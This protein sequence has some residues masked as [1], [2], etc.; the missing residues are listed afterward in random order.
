M[1]GEADVDEVAGELRVELGPR[2]AFV[3]VAH[4]NDVGIDLPVLSEV[5]E[6][7]GADGASSVAHQPQRRGQDLAS[8]EERV[9]LV[10][11][12]TAM[13]FGVLKRELRLL[14]ARASE[15]SSDGSARDRSREREAS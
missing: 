3:D 14:R 11:S 12:T 13:I 7:S 9:A 8:L 1:L 2:R 5:L 6:A 4:S 15:P 10:E